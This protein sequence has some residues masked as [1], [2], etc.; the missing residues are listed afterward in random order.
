MNIIGFDHSLLFA[1]LL[2]AIVIGAPPNNVVLGIEEE[3]DH[4]HEK[5]EIRVSIG[6]NSVATLEVEEAEIVVITDHEL[7]DGMYDISL[8][9]AD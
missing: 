8:K 6:P 3:A 5:E 4:H 9:C 1:V 2:T 7:P